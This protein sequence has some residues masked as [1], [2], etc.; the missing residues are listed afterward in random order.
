MLGLWRWTSSLCTFNLLTGSSPST[1]LG[2]KTKYLYGHL[3]QL[4][5]FPSFLFF[6][7]ISKELSTIYFPTSHSLLYNLQSD[8]T[9]PQSHTE[10][11][12][13]KK[14]TLWLNLL[15]AS[16]TFLGHLSLLITSSYM[17]FFWLPGKH[18]FLIFSP[19]FSPDSY[20]SLF[21][22]LILFFPAP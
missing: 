1:I 7:H 3:S 22:S 10:I 14:V 13:F 16:Q 5:T 17:V 11:V 4:D 20:V 8:T 21:L 12:L 15:T 19:H 9:Y 2:N 6:I 18:T